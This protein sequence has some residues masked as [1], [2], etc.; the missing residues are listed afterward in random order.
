MELTGYE[1]PLDQYTQKELAQIAE[2]Y[3]VY[4]KTPS[5][6]GKMGSGY[7]RLPKSKLIEI[8]RGDNDYQSEDPRLPKSR[9]GGR[10]KTKNR[11]EPIVFNLIGGESQDQLMNEILD[12][13][14]DT[15]VGYTPVPGR[16]Y[17]YIYYA[18]TPKLLYDR[19]PLIE[20]GNL[21]ERGF[22]GFNYHLGKIRKYNTVDG[23][24]LVSG[25]Y[26]VTTAEFNS[27]LKIPY[28]KIVRNR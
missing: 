16:Y 1:K 4:Y 17:T 9:V 19:Y 22:Y 3:K 23:D 2:K 10:V 27:L 24:R 13:L 20:A 12:A 26:E 6:V 28:K 15:N 5:G 7:S 11:I 14:Q 25:L 8:I 18:K 21:L